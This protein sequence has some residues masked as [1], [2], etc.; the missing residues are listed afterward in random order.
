G[1]PCCCG[2]ARGT[3][4]HER[5]SASLGLAGGKHLRGRHPPAMG[6]VPLPWTSAVPPMLVPGGVLVLGDADARAPCLAAIPAAPAGRTRRPW[7]RA[8]LA[9][10]LAAFPLVRRHAARQ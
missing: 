1:C 5:G 4:C 2:G 7:T 10:Q 6:R 9:R 3:C 8:G